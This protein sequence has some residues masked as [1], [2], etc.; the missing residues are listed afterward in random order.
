MA[1]KTQP[2]TYNYPNFKPSEYDFS[3]FAGLEAGQPFKDAVVTDIDDGT[4]RIGDLLDNP[5]VLEMGS[6][7]CPMYAQ[8]APPMQDHAARS[9]ELNYA[10]L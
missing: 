1:T 10:V 9:P 3:D 8:S 7:T 4:L 5:L 2:K 6:M